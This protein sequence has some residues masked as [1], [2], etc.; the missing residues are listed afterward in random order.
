MEF[1]EIARFAS[2]LEAETIG[3]ALDQYGIE[4]FVQSPDIGMFGPGNIGNTPGGVGLCVPENRS[5]EAMKLLH[6]AVDSGNELA[7]D[8]DDPVT[9]ER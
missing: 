8:S 5:E 4:F 2:R 1:K 3:H 6:C 7:D 9:D